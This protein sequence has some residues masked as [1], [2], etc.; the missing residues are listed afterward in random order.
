VR[1]D[2]V[3]DLQ[4]GQ[5]RA[6]VHATATSQIPYV[7][8]A[9]ITWNGL[10]LTDVKEM[11]FP[12]PERYRLQ[13]GDVLLSEASGSP[14]E[15]GKPAIWRDEIPGACYQKT[16]IRVRPVDGELVR[17]E[18]LRLVL[19]RDCVTGK[20]ARLAP[21]IGIVH[22]TA[23][24]MLPWPIPLPPLQEQDAIVQAAEEQLS[25]VAHVEADID[26]KHESS[27]SLRRAVLHHAFS[28][29]LVP[30]D[31]NDEP[32]SELLKRIAADRE[33]RQAP[34][35]GPTRSARPRRRRRVAAAGG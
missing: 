23:E 33:G 29:K 11:G 9:N 15:A 3:S 25:T 20:F 19:L 4:L 13:N 7:R 24:R 14:M 28:G 26:A 35:P 32:A 8:A 31:P 12:N 34:S 16:V 30:Q 21:G 2:Q 27:H 5:Q 6:P 17:S 10:D 22:L 18:F 1:L